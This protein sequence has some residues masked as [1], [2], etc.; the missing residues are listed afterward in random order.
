MQ[1]FSFAKRY[2]QVALT[3]V[4]STAL[5]CPGAARLWAHDAAARQRALD[6]WRNLSSPPSAPP[7]VFVKGDKVQFYFQ[8][9]TQT[10][11][12]AA[13][14]FPRRAPTKGYRVAS[15]RLRLD[16]ERPPMPQGER[17]WHEA[18]VIAGPEWRKLT[19][20]LLAS[21][22][23]TKP[24]H[25]FYY[26]GFL[27]DRVVFRDA[28]GAPNIASIGEQPSTIVIDGHFS[29]EET[30]QVVAQKVE[31]D[32]ARNHPGDSLFVLM[33]PNAKRFPQPLLLDRQK[34]RCIW[35]SPA[36]M[37]D[38]TERGFPLANTTQ[39]IWAFLFESHGLALVKNPLSSAARLVDVGAQ[40]ILRFMRLPLPKPDH[41][42][43]P[44]PSAKGMDLVAWE[45]WLDRYTG[46]RYQ[47]GSLE[48]LIDGE[49]FF[50][51]LHQAISQATNHVHFDLYI[52][53]RDDVGVG[54]ADLLRER[55]RDLEVQLLLDRMGCLSAGNVPPATPMPEDFT[56]PS[57]IGSYLRKDS[58]VHVRSFLNPWFSAEH[59]KLYLVDGY[60]AWVGGMNVGREYRYEWH[61]LMVELQ[62]P[63]V[64]SLE[65]DFRH[66]WAHAGA[67][68]DLAYI[69]SVLTPQDERKIPP[70]APNSA[71]IR[72]LPTKTGWKP[73]S[74][75]VLGAIRQAQSYIYVEN[76]YLFDK[77]V[78]RALVD[79]R[80]RGVDVRVIMPGI[81][82]FEA[83]SRSNLVTAN[84]LHQHGVRVYFYPG[85]THV[86]A[87]LVDDW[88][89]L[90][91]SNLNHL[92]L[93]LCQEHNIAT[94]DPAFVGRLKNELFAP[95]FS[96]SSELSEAISIDWMDVLSDLVLENF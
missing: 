50:P 75:A 82:D 43:P 61:D 28:Q 57:S 80:G 67:L 64:A 19:T 35:L 51:R 46:T 59:S 68:G 10:V 8:N 96:R 27:A 40:T 48:L 14:W 6:E 31:S 32:L 88:A 41:P 85:M 13:S 5:L 77:K 17:S 29:M 84:Y 47:Q 25:G 15:A 86:K 70:P 73:F 26:Q 1:R 55:S 22:A 37:Y 83:A 34:R 93:R 71:K 49:S 39:G 45:A 52:F 95:D 4:L 21:L 90:G 9:E 3:T 76:S 44:D 24:G 53:D 69:G 11:V 92:S 56:P 66:A 91:S 72:L 87:I 74:A 78:V 60:R 30:L 38:S 12:F 36:A 89:A 62:G 20:N 7:R 18:T 81:N 33:A 23:P 79:A 94:T 42:P 54:L 63:V 65:E 16:Q 58:K 2:G